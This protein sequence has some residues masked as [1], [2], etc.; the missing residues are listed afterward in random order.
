MSEYFF[1]DIPQQRDTCSLSGSLE[2]MTWTLSLLNPTWQRLVTGRKV[3]HI[4]IAVWGLGDR[5]D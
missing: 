2:N 1:I 4:G 5:G 3:L